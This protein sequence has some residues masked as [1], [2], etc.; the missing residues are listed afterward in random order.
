M[1]LSGFF[2]ELE[3]SVKILKPRFRSGQE[4]LVKIYISC[5]LV[6]KPGNFMLSKYNLHY[7]HDNCDDNDKH[8]AN[9]HDTQHTT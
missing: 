4:S 3:I 5:R 7:A 9:A 6:L 1:Q 2:K 8:N